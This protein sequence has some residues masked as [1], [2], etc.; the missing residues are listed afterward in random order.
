[1]M[2]TQREAF[3]LRVLTI[4]QIAE[5]LLIK[6]PTSVALAALVGSRENIELAQFAKILFLLKNLGTE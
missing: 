4:R 1:M 2:C 3:I 5:G 6:A